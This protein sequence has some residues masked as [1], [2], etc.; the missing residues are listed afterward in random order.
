[1]DPL[2]LC[3]PMTLNSTIAKTT[4]YATLA[5]SGCAVLRLLRKAVVPEVI[6]S[7]R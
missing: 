3:T 1:M 5:R 4:K 7:R 2:K 6:V